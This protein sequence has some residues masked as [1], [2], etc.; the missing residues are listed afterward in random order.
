[1]AE[2]TDKNENGKVSVRRE[3]ITNQIKLYF[4]KFPQS[5]AKKCCENLGLDYNYYR[6]FC[7]RIKSETRSEKEGKVQARQLN[8]LTH[9]IEF[10]LPEHLRLDVWNSV[11]FEALRRQ[12]KGEPYP[13]DEWFIV[14]NRNKM[15]MLRNEFV[16]IR[17][18]PRSNRLF[19]LPHKPMD[20]KD[21]RI[22][23]QNALFKT[24]LDLKECELLS[25]KLQPSDKHRVFHIGQVSPFKIDFYKPSL[26]LTLKA[27][28][29]HPEHLEAVETSPAWIPAM[30]ESQRKLTESNVAVSNAVARNT[31]K[32]D[33]NTEI[34]GKYTEQVA[35]HLSVLK[36]IGEATGRLTEAVKTIS[37]TDE[38]PKWVTEFLLRFDKLL[39]SMENTDKKVMEGLQQVRDHDDVLSRSVL[40]LGSRMIQ[41]R[42]R[43]AAKPK[44]R[45]SRF[46][47]LRRRLQR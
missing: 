17:V 47:R 7:Y 39:V 25:E 18:Y 8:P 16:S 1:M 44:P 27:D 43:V 10:I 30:L 37:K 14:P 36:D 45:P 42:K 5:S 3:G 38:V 32:M 41:K 6:D 15:R 9:R 13:V 28:G 11:N 34:L 35:L 26:G 19:V 40:T 2:S 29:S 21:V 33:R 12:P 24:G 20:W 23:F 22:C 46:Q 31:E 4:W